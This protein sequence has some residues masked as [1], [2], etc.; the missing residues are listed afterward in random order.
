MHPALHPALPAAPLHLCTSTPLHLYTSVPLYPFAA[1]P[2]DSAR[3]YLF[4]RRH[5]LGLHQRSPGMRPVPW[6]TASCRDGSAAATARDSSALTDSGMELGDCVRPKRIPECRPGALRSPPAVWIYCYQVLA[7][8]GLGKVSPHVMAF[9][10]GATLL[11]S[12]DTRMDGAAGAA[13]AAAATGREATAGAAVLASL[14]YVS[15]YENQG[16]LAVR[17]ARGCRCEEQLLDAHRAYAAQ[18]RNVSVVE[19]H[20]FVITGASATCELQLRVRRTTSSGGHQF[21]LRGLKLRAPM[22]RFLREQGFEL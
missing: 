17:C 1:A 20:A 2:I 10:P 7:P 3:C 16:R 21:Q 13:G 8:S 18:E 9:A 22:G 14:S 15:S 12:L 4:G 5:A 11:A 19:E 6:D